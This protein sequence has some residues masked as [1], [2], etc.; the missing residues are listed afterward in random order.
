LAQNRANNAPTHS[1]KTRQAIEL[2]H[3]SGTF[4]PQGAMK[5]KYF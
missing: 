4:L 1:A 5:P 2:E 3:G